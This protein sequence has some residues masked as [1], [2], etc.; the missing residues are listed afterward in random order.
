MK[1]DI[2][3]EN[4]N[5][6]LREETAP[7]RPPQI[8]G[9]K[10]QEVL[11][12]LTPYINKSQGQPGPDSDS[13]KAIKSEQGQKL[14]AALKTSKNPVEAAKLFVLLFNLLSDEDKA[15]IATIAAKLTQAAQ[16]A[17]AT[18]K[19]K[20][21]SEPPVAAPTKIVEVAPVITQTK[22]SATTTKTAKPII[23]QTKGSSTTPAPT[24]LTPTPAEPAK[25]VE[26]TV[27]DKINGFAIKGLASIGS[28]DPLKGMKILSGGPFVI[29]MAMALAD[30]ASGQH[31]KGVTDIAN[32][33]FG[34]V[35]T[36][37]TDDLGKILDLQM[38]AISESKDSIS[39]IERQLQNAT[40]DD[41]TPVCPACLLEIIEL[42]SGILFEAKYQGR[43][44]SLN[45]P[46]KGD[47]KK[48]K[49]YVKD[50]KT[51]NI[52][53]V[54]FGDKNMT[55]KKNIPARRKSFRAR[56]KC[57]QKKDKTSAGYWSCKAWE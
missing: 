21:T 18:P 33:I 35:R 2:I 28:G 37:N 47:V 20:P 57:D 4:W 54:N 13:L 34:L 51:G 6:F 29:G 22:G 3:T 40:L 43:T 24:T 27:T 25:P 15:E 49:V 8:D 26:K 32:N 17:P 45:K 42:T 31:A 10:P 41:G 23:T 44:V 19:P 5:K 39:L 48:S 52:K 56:H 38:D 1:Y 55:I 30:I 11:K 16:K 46:M 12:L 36:M 53:K 50:P 7:V 9:S 14:F